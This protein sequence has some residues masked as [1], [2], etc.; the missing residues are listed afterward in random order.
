MPVDILL[1][2][3]WRSLPA[4]VAALPALSARFARRIAA[5]GAT[6]GARLRTWRQRRRSRAELAEMDDRA[7]HDLGSSR[8]QAM[9]EAS[10]PF[11]RA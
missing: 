3:A 10:K 7:L 4:F 11:W 9:F 2:F 1:G 5:A 8:G 6:L